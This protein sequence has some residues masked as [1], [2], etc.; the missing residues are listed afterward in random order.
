MINE[1]DNIRLVVDDI[2]K[3]GGK[4]IKKLDGYVVVC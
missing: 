4:K 2:K 1:K 3:L